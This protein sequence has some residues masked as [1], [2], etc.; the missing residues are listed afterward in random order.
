MTDRAN[1]K[2][3]YK[4]EILNR[5]TQKTTRHTHAIMALR[6]DDFTLEYYSQSRIV[7]TR[8]AARVTSVE[9]SGHVLLLEKV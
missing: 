2:A 3:A 9:Q 6:S 7:R 5:S 4:T 1:T 8:H